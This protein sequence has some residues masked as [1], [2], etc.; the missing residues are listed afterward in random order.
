MNQE[1]KDAISRASTLPPSHADDDDFAK[2]LA[3]PRTLATL[4]AAFSN[5]PHPV[6][7]RVAAT[8]VIGTIEDEIV[9][10][11]CCG[12]MAVKTG[13]SDETYWQAPAISLLIEPAQ[14]EELE[15]I[16]RIVRL[17]GQAAAD[18]GDKAEGNADR[19][20]VVAGCRE[21]ENALRTLVTLGLFSS[22]QRAK[23]AARKELPL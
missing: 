5:C 23:Q 7:C 14:L 8:A 17:S 21:L 15:Q 20:D 19:A 1:L 3:E 18:L 16:E 6:R 10:C 13:A 4:V 12:A 11:S 22:V 9:W 2:V